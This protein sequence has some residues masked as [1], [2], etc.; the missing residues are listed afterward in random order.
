M[1]DISNPMINFDEFFD[2]ESLKQ[3]DLVVWM[4]LDMHHLPRRG[5]CKQPFLQR[6]EMIVFQL[7]MYADQLN[8]N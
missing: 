1:R 5:D 3:E 8:P 7:K 4:N 6:L 2:G